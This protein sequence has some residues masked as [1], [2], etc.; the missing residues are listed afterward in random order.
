MGLIWRTMRRLLLVLVGSV[1]VIGILAPHASTQAN[2]L[3][4]TW[5]LVRVERLGPKGDILPA[6]A[7][8][9][10]GSPN[11]VGVLMYDPNGYMGV[12]IMQSGRQKY[13][14]VEPTPDEAKAALASYVSYFGTFSV[15]EAG[16]IVTHHVQGSLNPSM[17][18]EPRRSYQISGN[19]L[20]LKTPRSSTGTQAQLIWERVPDLAQLTPEHRRFIGFWK[21]VTT[22]R[23]TADGKV[24]PPEPRPARVGFLIYTTAGYMAVHLMDPGRPKYKGA[25]PT[26]EEAQMALRTYGSAYF[27]PYTIHQTEGYVVH[28]QLGMINPGGGVGTDTIRG[29]RFEG[30]NRLVL[31]PPKQTVNGQTVQSFVTWERVTPRITASE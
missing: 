14:G 30:D 22:E 18:P 1:G 29:Y 9:A 3:A 17:E 5:K 25:Q 28:H 2:R 6:P 24:L 12:T 23:R 21:P 26:P 15:D 4:G 8:P 13:A 10:F 20:S 16:G 31:M 27:G 11:P 7:A 19:R